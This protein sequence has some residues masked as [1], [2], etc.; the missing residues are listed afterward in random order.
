MIPLLY[1]KSSL[2]AKL[3]KQ[4]EKNLFGGKTV[5][6]CTDIDGT[7]VADI[8]TTSTRIEFQRPRFTQA[9]VAL[10]NYLNEYHIP[11]IAL[12]GR[13]LYQVFN[14][15]LGGPNYEDER[16]PYFD[17][18]APS[19]GTLVYVLSEEGGGEY[20]PDTL[21]E[22]R[23]QDTSSFDRA[24]LYPVVEAMFTSLNKKYPDLKLRFQDKDSKTNLFAYDKLSGQS[25]SID[26]YR[27]S[28]RGKAEIVGTRTLEA[29]VNDYLRVAGYTQPVIVC[30]QKDDQIYIDIAAVEKSFAVSYFKKLTGVDVV[31]VAGDSGNDKLMLTHAT[32]YGVVAG[33]AHNDLIRAIRS[34]PGIKQMEYYVVLPNGTPLYIEPVKSDSSFEG[35]ESLQLAFATY[36]TH[37]LKT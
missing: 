11:I 34:E 29:L 33:A 1:R 21:Y 22:K 36:L 6:A 35:P 3:A 30:A 15:Q 7:Y 16:L 26:R 18:I 5:I 32:D 4:K 2:M 25:V 28:L 19:L 24:A 27:I 37:I 13:Q 12:T 23:V 31:L 17:I 14:G 10:T 20:E 9:T 8:D